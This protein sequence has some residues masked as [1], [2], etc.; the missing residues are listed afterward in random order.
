M[1]DCTCERSTRAHRVPDNLCQ[2]CREDRADARCERRIQAMYECCVARMAT[3]QYENMRNHGEL[4]K[5]TA[6]ELQDECVADALMTL[7][8]AQRAVRE[9]K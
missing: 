1:S 3:E 4:E 2:R 5:C 8:A 7:R 9:E 6:L